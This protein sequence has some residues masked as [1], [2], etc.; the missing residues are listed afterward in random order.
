NRR[1]VT[2]RHAAAI[3]EDRKVFTLTPMQPHRLRKKADGSND[4]VVQMWFP[5]G[6]GGVGGGEERLAPHSNSALGW[7]MTEAG[8]SGLSF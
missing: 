4:Q 3:D 1:I 5:G 8:K 2:A 7:M 6:H